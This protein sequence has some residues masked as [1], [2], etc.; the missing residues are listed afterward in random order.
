MLAVLH[1][2]SERAP[3]FGYAV[4]QRPESPFGS[5]AAH[6][7]VS[8]EPG[9]SPVGVRAWRVAFDDGGIVWVPEAAAMAEY[10]VDETG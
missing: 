10:V 4:G 6:K 9:K 7:V 2:L 3:A 8:I 5:R 1:V